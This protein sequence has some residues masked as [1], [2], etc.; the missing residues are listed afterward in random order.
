MPASDLKTGGC[1][2]GAI[3]YELRGDAKMLYICHCRDCQKQSSSAFGMSLIVA[4]ETLKF[5]AGEA[6]LRAWDTRGDNGEIKRCHF[7]P[8]C[9]SRIFHGS[10][11]PADEISIK[12]GSLDDTGWLRP[13]AQIWLKS[14]QSWTGFDRAEMRG[15]DTEP[16]DEAELE[17]LWHERNRDS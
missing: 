15:Y 11:N 9:G 10:D 17:L 1:Q 14:A 2:C 7:C 5:T 16:E 12:A 6:R 8:E 13:V 3:R 4:P